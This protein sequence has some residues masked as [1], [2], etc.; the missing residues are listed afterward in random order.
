MREFITFSGDIK[1]S[2]PNSLIT[3]RKVG[4]LNFQLE[5]IEFLFEEENNDGKKESDREIFIYIFTSQLRAL[6]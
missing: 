4:A 1:N 2:R 6:V 3:S 5:K